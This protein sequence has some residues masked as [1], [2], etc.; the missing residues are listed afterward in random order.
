MHN[1]CCT[2]FPSGHIP[3][4]RSLTKKCKSDLQITLLTAFCQSAD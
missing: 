2:A 1:I 4:I 3:V